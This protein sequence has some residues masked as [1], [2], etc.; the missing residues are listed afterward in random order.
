MGL[1]G[2]ADCAVIGV[3]DDQW[4]ETV[5]AVVVLGAGASLSDRAVIDH[6]RSHLAAFKCP[7]SVDFVDELPRNGTGKVLKTT[8]REPYWKGHSRR[9]AG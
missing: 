6:A 7:R 3:P 1:T 8:L 4:G 9:V 2:V 5:K